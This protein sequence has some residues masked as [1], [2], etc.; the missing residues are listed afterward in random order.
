MKKILTAAAAAAFLFFGGAEAAQPGLTDASPRIFAAEAAR[1]IVEAKYPVWQGPS[2]MRRARINS[3]VE[4]EIAYFYEALKKWN[5]SAPV[6]GWVTWQVGRA[7]GDVVSLVLFKTTAPKGAAHPTTAVVGM[8]FDAE[9]NRI[10][11]K[12]IGRRLPAM[13][14]EEINAAIDREAEVRGIPLF[15]AEFRSVRDWPRDF[16]IGADGMVYFIFQ[17]Y[18]IAPY[19]SGWIAVPAGEYK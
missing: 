13:T 6:R 4:A 14:A 1:D 2:A 18:D 8:T 5:A 10:T 7:D 15:P 11:R 16:Y 9:G 19:S 12:D 3:A 17:Q